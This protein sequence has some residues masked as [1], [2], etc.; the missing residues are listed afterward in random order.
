LNVGPLYRLRLLTPRLELRLGSH[1]ELLAL[2]Q[3]AKEGVHPPAEMPFAVAW[4]DRIGEE[5]F[6]QS[7]VEYHDA[8][9]RD[10]KPED[11]RL[12]LL[13]F[14][15]GELAGSQ[16]ISAEHLATQ[17]E[18]STGSWL[19]KRFQRQGLGTEMRA[20]VLELAFRKL[21]A[22][23]A[24]SGA[25]VGSEASKRVSE[26]LGYSITGTSTVSP[27]GEPLMHYDLLINKDAWLAPVPVE[28]LGLGACLPLFGI[29]ESS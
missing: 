24:T 14:T 21:G 25:I 3:L 1:Q 19:G 26:K 5:D 17:R 6:V 29:S 9:L 8:T 22:A 16:S 20:A 2:A 13:V 18:V 27:R 12:N 7:V 28:I 23:K 10:W 11:W 4:T 15:S